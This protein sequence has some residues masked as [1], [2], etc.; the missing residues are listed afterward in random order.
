MAIG[1]LI[2]IWVAIRKRW[3]IYFFDSPKLEMSDKTDKGHRIQEESQERTWFHI[4]V[5]NRPSRRYVPARNVKVICTKIER[6]HGEKYEPEDI[7]GDFPLQW[8]YSRKPPIP[9]IY[10]EDSFDLG[11]LV[12]QRDCII[13]R[14]AMSGYQEK[15]NLPIEIY[16]DKSGPSKMRVHLRIESDG[17]VSKNEYVYE[18]D[19]TKDWEKK[20]LGEIPVGKKV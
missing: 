11:Y 20:Y 13:F 7:P 8:V 3:F 4:R 15:W 9:A 12:K 2:S 14:V 18:I 16:S 1:S 17:F 5:T 10:T 6:F 19:L